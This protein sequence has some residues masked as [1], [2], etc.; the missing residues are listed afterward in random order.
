MLNPVPYIYVAPLKTDTCRWFV[1]KVV[2]ELFV[3]DVFLVFYPRR[4]PSSIRDH[5][6]I[7]E[8]FFYPVEIKALRT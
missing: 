5:N 8:N 1:E 2:E 7:Y 3:E 6:N 4:F